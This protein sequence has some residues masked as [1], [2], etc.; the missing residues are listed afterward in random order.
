M[1]KGLALGV[2]IGGTLGAS[3]GR[4]FQ[5]LE[6]RA[7]RAN[8]N[9]KKAK[10]GETL[11]K[12]LQKY[13][14]TLEQL[15][16][17]Q[18]GLGRS[19][20]K[21]AKGI[22][23]VTRRYRE[24][25]RKAKEYGISVNDAAEQQKRFTREVQRSERELAKVGRRK[26]IGQALSDAKGQIAAAAG[27]GYVAARQAGNAMNFDRAGTQL[28]TVINAQDR[29]SAVERSKVGAA[30]YARKS[31]ATEEELLEAEYM[32]NSAGLSEE[33]SR[34]GARE[35]SK[36]AKVTRG[37]SGVVGS[38]MAD[39]YNNFGSQLA[40]D[41]QQRMRAVGDLLAKTQATYAIKDFGQLGE[42]IKTSAAALSMNRVDLA[43]GISLVGMA[44]SLGIKG[45]EAGTSITASMRQMS[46]AS[47]E[48]GFDLARNENGGLD[49]AATVQ[50]LSDAI[51]GF[52]ELDQD[53]LDKLQ[54]VFGDE[55]IRFTVLFG[56]AMKEWQVN[57]KK[58]EGRDGFV[59]AEYDVFL[60]DAQGQWER[61]TGNISS[62][63]R[64]I[65]S[66][67]L[68]VLSPLIGGLADL[69]GWLGNVIDRSPAVGVALGSMVTGF[70]AYKAIS[71]G[72]A[73]ATG[74]FGK[75][76][77]VVTHKNLRNAIGGLGKY[78]KAMALARNAGLVGLA[79]AGG[80]VAGS[81]IYD[82][83]LKG[84]DAG[85]YIGESIARVLAFFGNEEAQKAI[86]INEANKSQVVTQTNHITL[87]TLPG[88]NEEDIANRVKD[89]LMDAQGR[90]LYDG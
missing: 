15:K 88:Q 77:D 43:Q 47:E 59:D 71:I 44:N 17:K 82:R 56:K 40:G 34:A 75:A 30:I 85:D 8:Q 28:G 66:S 74:N 32:L 5:T 68:P 42:G 80:Y 9:L 50:N 24:A 70:A 73:L 23:D 4:S 13:K 83:T 38:V 72:A 61:L 16:A 12:D 69:T 87:N 6:D 78:T 45:S 79:G 19:S 58:L 86:A 31:L 10:V 90:A 54:Q 33:A 18:D 55:G 1:D 63:G 64:A 57:N 14:R 39:V 81:E 25:K 26:R 29:K 67:L 22:E 62:L 51:G 2:V 46:K 27:A 36:V 53:T 7:K 76:L 65:G 21:L 52:D 48:F 3:V 49:Y 89:K 11:A 37:A 35:A 20:P 60:K 84:T 41:E